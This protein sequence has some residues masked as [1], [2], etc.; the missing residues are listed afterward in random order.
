LR[1]SPNSTAG[2]NCEYDDAVLGQDDRTSLPNEQEDD[3]VDSS[4]RKKRKG[5]GETK[6][7]SRKDDEEE[8]TERLRKKIGMS[9]HIP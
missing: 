4:K 6:R 8:E 1:T 5:T 7:K 3:D 2:I 9:G